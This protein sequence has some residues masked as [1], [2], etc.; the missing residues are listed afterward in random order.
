MPEQSLL[1]KPIIEALRLLNDWFRNRGIS[2]AI[3]GG[4]AVSLLAEPRVTK[5]IDALVWLAD[6]DWKKFL[7]S[8]ASF[9]FFPRI[10]DALDFARLR[11]VLLLKHEPTGVDI[12]ISFGAL[13][14]ELE[15]IEAALERDV[16]NFQI[17]VPRLTDLVV[18]KAVA[19]RPKDVLDIVRIL[20]LHKDLDFN[21]IRYWVGE[22]AAVLETPEMLDSLERL[23]QQRIK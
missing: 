8:G 20:D 13:P 11:R 4:V 17:R 1:S 23:I 15:A 12:D 3:I 16:L 10:S 6:D 18:M 14:F 22:F 9:G 19:M 7:D 21:R 5:D 2:H